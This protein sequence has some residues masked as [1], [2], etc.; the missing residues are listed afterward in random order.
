[1][2]KNLGIN[3]RQMWEELNQALV[4]L[5]FKKEIIN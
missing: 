5:E 2:E 1:M 3:D 4:T